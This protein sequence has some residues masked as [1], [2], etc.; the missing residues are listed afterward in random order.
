M[1]RENT[2]KKKKKS[3]ASHLVSIFPD[4]D[5]SIVENI[6]YTLVVN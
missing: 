5:E 2:L 6:K 1:K 3:V 4:E